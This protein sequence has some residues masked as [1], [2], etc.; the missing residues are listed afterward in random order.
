M[1]TFFG[2]T[3]SITTSPRRLSSNFMRMST[4]PR[5]PMMPS[6]NMSL[7]FHSHWFWSVMTLNTF[8]NTPADSGVAWR[9]GWKLVSARL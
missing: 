6:A 7:R 8:A 5:D 4:K 3:F 9:R 2:F 1:S